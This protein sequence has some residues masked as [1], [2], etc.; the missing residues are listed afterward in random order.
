MTMAPI[1][2]AVVMRTLKATLPRAMYV[3]KLLAWPPLM[4]PTSTI[5]A[6]RAGDKPNAWLSPSAKTGIIP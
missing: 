6:V 2:V 3:H 5:P 4:L 1:V